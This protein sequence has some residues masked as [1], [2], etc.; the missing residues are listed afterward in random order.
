MEQ[1]GS[2]ATSNS[3]EDYDHAGTL[4]VVGSDTSQNHPVIAS[5][6]RR[7]IEKNGA[8]LVVVN[9]IRIDLADLAD[10]F[11]QPKPGTDVAVFNAIANVILAEKLWDADFVGARTEGFDGWRRAA[12]RATP[13]EAERVSGVPADDI[14]R[15]ARLYARPHKNGSCLLWGMGVT[16]HSMGTDNARSLVN[17]ALLCGQVGKF[18][19]GILAAARAEQRAGL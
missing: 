1:V 15:A 3:Y 18:G 7:A 19:S 14:R 12:E 9:P 6:L 10:V 13:E 2:G 17:L 5:R 16:Q 11:L 8:K 4:M